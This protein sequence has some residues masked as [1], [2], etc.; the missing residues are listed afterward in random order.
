MEIDEHLK[1]TLY[2]LTVTLRCNSIVLIV[3]VCNSTHAL[4]PE[5]RWFRDEPLTISSK[6]QSTL[7]ILNRMMKHIGLIPDATLS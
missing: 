5:S 6:P 4:V 1:Y 7:T 3:T 2:V